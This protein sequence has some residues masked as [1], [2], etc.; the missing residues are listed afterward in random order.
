MSGTSSTKRRK[1]GGGILQKMS[2]SILSLWAFITQYEVELD[3][4]SDGES[5]QK[6]TLGSARPKA[7]KADGQMFE[8][9]IDES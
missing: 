7:K 2:T 8:Y 9:K 6:F 5:I 4:E 1:S 3:N